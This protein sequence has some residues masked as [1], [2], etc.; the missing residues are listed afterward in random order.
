M[1]FRGACGALLVAVLSLVGAPA[2]G[3][4]QGIPMEAEAPMS[5]LFEALTGAGVIS[6]QLQV[7]LVLVFN[8]RG[9]LALTIRG[10]APADVLGQV[11]AALGDN[12]ADQPE[13]GLEELTS[14]FFPATSSSRDG[15]AI[16]LIT[17]EAALCAPC[18]DLAADFLGA[19]ATLLRET[20][21]VVYVL[22]IQRDR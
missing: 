12:N 7:P 21:V 13:V 14:R 10:R 9:Q 16:L 6:E 8:H 18:K 2:W 19:L 22:T 20:E 3:G 4:V 1:G 15:G 11:T 17:M 5:E